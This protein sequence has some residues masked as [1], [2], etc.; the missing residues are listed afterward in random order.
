AIIVTHSAVTN[1]GTFTPQGAR[2]YNRLKSLPNVFMLLC[3]HIGGRE[4]DG[5]HDGEA[6]RQRTFQGNTIKAFLSNYQSRPKGGNGLMRLYT[7][8]PSK[9]L[10]RIRTINPYTGIPETDSGSR[11]ERPLYHGFTT[12]RTSDFNNDGKSQLSVFNAGTWKVHG[13]VD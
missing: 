10:I 6:Y 5:L 13:E 8:F 7:I 1:A 12:T 9:D 3:G 11:F 2:I 4:E